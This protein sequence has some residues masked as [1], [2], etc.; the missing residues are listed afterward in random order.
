VPDPS[1]HEP[2]EASTPPL[3]F[4]VPAHLSGQRLA[5]V[6]RELVEGRSGSQLQKLVRRGRVKR[7]GLKTL[8]SNVRVEAGDRINVRFVAGPR[9]PEPAAAVFV[10]EDEHLAVVIKPPGLLCHPTDR[11]RLRALSDILVDRY[12]ELPIVQGSNRPGIVH[13]LDR[14]TSGLMVVARQE[15]AMRGLI[16]QFRSRQIEKRYLALCHRAGATELEQD[17][18]FLVDRP[19]EPLPGHPD[20]QRIAPSGGKSSTTHAVARELFGAFVLVEC[21]P[22]TGRRHQI[23]VHMLSSGLPLVGDKLYGRSDVEPWPAEAPRASRQ[24]LHAAGL[25]L[26]HPVTGE[27]LSFSSEPWEDMAGQ[28]EWLRSRAST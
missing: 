28:L 3:E 7:N 4:L 18:E 5:E 12:G 19:L 23:R 13:R 26:T 24:A 21:R 1:A 22:K 16:A 8:R 20:R 14:E 15:E 6:L 27:K 10:H 2:S 9:P 17:Q 11:L 25:A